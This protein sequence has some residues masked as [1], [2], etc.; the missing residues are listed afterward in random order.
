MPKRT[1]TT[2]TTTARRVTRK[3]AAKRQKVGKEGTAAATTTTTAVVGKP[4][5]SQTPSPSVAVAVA[6]QK[7]Q[8]LAAMEDVCKSQMEKMLDVYKEYDSAQSQR[9]D[10]VRSD[11]RDLSEE[12]KE[13]V[14]CVME[15]VG[16]V[17]EKLETVDKVALRVADSGPGIPAAERERVLERFVRL[18]PQRSEPGNGLGLSLVRAVARLHGARLTLGDN[19]PGLVVTLAFAKPDTRT[20]EAA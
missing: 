8:L 17:E 6:D 4:A 9:I 12:V 3:A 13:N 2:A 16:D 5:P 19:R 7:R 14:E 1:A 20:A 15:R 11:F 10:A 18:D